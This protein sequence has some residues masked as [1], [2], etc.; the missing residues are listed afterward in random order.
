MTHQAAESRVQSPES[1]RSTATTEHHKL[2]AEDGR[3]SRREER[4]EAPQEETFKPESDISCHRLRRAGDKKK[5]V[6]QRISITRFA[7]SCVK[8]QGGAGGAVVVRSRATVLHFF[9]QLELKF[10]PLFFLWHR[11]SLL[12]IEAWHAVLHSCTCTPSQA[13]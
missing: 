6:H 9:L 8:L 11:L 2:G 10:L 5:K 4:T 12:G 3:E 7:F 13:F 1:Q